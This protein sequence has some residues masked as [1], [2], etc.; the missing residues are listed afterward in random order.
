MQLRGQL[1]LEK[2]LDV[3]EAKAKI[4]KAEAAWVASPP[5]HLSSPSPPSA[6]SPTSALAPLR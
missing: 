5:S 4:S 6:C 3:L 2:A 1:R